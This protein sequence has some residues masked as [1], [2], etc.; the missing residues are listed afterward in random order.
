[1]SLFKNL[2]LGCLLGLVTFFFLAPTSVFAQTS[3]PAESAQGDR[4]QTLRQLLAE[5]RELRLAM[6]RATVTNARFQM[7]IERL[8]AQQGQVEVLSRQLGTVRSQ[9]TKLKAARITGLAEMK[10]I[11]EKASQASEQEQAAIERVLKE[12]KLVLESKTAEEQQQLEAEADLVMRLQVEQARLNE[13]NS[14]LDM[15]I[16]EMKGP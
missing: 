11:E 1:M 6:Q 2:S 13:L 12:S 3:K 4:D 8:K 16:N 10:E 15:L 9:L 7:L 14:Q 5:V